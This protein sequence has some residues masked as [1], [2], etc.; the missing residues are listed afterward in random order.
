M[1]TVTSLVVLAAIVLAIKS[2]DRWITMAIILIAGIALGGTDFGH[3]VV[4]NLDNL[5][6]GMDGWVKSFVH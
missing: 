2:R 6:Q 3:S 5:A 1:I 4:S